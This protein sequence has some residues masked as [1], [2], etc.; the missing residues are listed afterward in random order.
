LLD[1]RNDS[2]LVV[3]GVD[4]VLGPTDLDSVRRAEVDAG[5][6][7]LRKHRWMVEQYEAMPVP[8]AAN[9]FELGIY[10]GGSTA[11]IAL[12]L[13]PRR[14]V[15]V[16]LKS[17]RTSTLDHFITARGLQEN[18][19]PH[20]GVDQSDRARVDEIVHAEFG[21]EPL[22]L[23]IDDA[24]H[25]LAETTASFNAL[26][27]RLRAG[28]LFVIEDWSW[29][30][31][32]ERLVKKRLRSDPEARETMA[33]RLAT[34]PE[35]GDALARHFAL[36]PEDGEALAQHLASDPTARAALARQLESSP[37]AREAL[38]RRPES[39]PPSPPNDSL[40]RLALELVLAAAYADGIVAE[41]MSVRAGWLIVRRGD[42]TVDPATFD[43]SEC[44]GQLGRALLT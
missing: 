9:V 11:L 25:L 14:L 42:A 17:N 8:P 22:D 36:N 2:H 44:Y 13:R 27:P 39:G 1:W 21:T 33:R 19:H 15:A 10:E 7:L 26:F 38:A 12:L 31:D 41:V 18:V 5:A 4:F 32:R 34:D 16:D 23:V 40:S 43:I 28:G 20:Y 24:S 29:Q 30:H 35:A 37:E 3:D 6:L